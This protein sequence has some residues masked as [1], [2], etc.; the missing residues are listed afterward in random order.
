VTL[1][2]TGIAASA[3]AV[4]LS[5]T[6]L[7]FASQAAGTSSAAQTVT[8]T[9]SGSTALTL[10]S[11]TLTGGQADDYVLTKSCGASLAA[12]ASCTLS[13]TF[14]PVSAGT[15]LANITIVDNASGSP[16]VVVLTGTGT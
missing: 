1:T 8:L 3:A 7:T 14:K 15:K 6:T 9:N 12:G 10:T 2:G 5:A 4:K 16:Q 11:I 13:V